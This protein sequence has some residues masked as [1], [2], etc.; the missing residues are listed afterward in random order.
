MRIGQIGQMY[1]STL[2]PHQSYSTR[3]QTLTNWKNHC[4]DCRTHA[5]M[6]IS[7][8][9]H[10]YSLVSALLPCLHETHLPEEINISIVL[11][12]I[13][14]RENDIYS[15]ECVSHGMWSRNLCFS[16]AFFIVH[17]LTLPWQL[18]SQTFQRGFAGSGL[19][20]ATCVRTPTTRILRGR[21]F[22]DVQKTRHPQ[23]SSNLR[24]NRKEHPRLSV[25]SSPHGF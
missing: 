21:S 4:N 24:K 18:I 13:F 14:F 9:L 19:I 7:D 12:Y 5:E 1:T 17:K 15:S 22:S 3:P 23:T 8:R 6:L 25:S 16:T 11:R 10:H 20:R 2:D